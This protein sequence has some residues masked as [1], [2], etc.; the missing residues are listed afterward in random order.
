M[1]P[2]HARTM[3]DTARQSRTGLLQRFRPLIWFGAC[4]LVV[5]FLTRLILLV[6]TG[7]GVPPRPSYWL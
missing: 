4:F 2:E 6:M 5:S 7:A 3:D 1:D